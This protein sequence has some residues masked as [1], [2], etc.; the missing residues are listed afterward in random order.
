MA[1]PV[2][3]SDYGN[4]PGTELGYSDFFGRPLKRGFDCHVICVNE[5]AGFQAV[6]RPDCHYVEVVHSALHS[7]KKDDADDTSCIPEARP[8]ARIP[9][10]SK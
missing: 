5:T 2:T 8:V 1:Y 6:S 4:V 10:Q 3:R 9:G 7:V